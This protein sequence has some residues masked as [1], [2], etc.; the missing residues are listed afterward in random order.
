M[1]MVSIIANF[2]AIQYDGTNSVEIA[3]ACANDFDV[4]SQINNVMTYTWRGFGDP[5]TASVGSWFIFSPSEDE[6]NIPRF[7]GIVLTNEEFNKL[8]RIQP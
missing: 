5:F 2:T 3:T 8:W 1:T 7:M 4:V 6:I